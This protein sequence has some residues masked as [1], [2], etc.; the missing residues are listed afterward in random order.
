MVEVLSLLLQQVVIGDWKIFVYNLI[1]TILF[2]VLGVIIGKVVAYGLRKLANKGNIATAIKPS[3][4]ELFIAVIKW[5]IYILFVEF[6]IEQ[7]NFPQLTNIVSMVLLTI[8]AI[9]GS[10]FIIGIGYILASYLKDI[11]EESKVIN[12]EILGTLLFFFVMYVF[13]VFALKTA[14]INFDSTTVN[15]I[16]I[17]LTAVVSATVAIGFL[18]F[19]KKK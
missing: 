5:S 6:G 2:I 7:L 8:P 9:V 16:L 10:L 12:W 13:S 17:I 15:I 11:V 1:Q 4:I 18:F 3:F 14:L 19:R